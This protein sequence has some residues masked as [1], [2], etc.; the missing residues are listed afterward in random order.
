ML[1]HVCMYYIQCMVTLLPQPLPYTLEHDV[2]V[3]VCVCCVCLFEGGSFITVCCCPV[4]GSNTSLQQYTQHYCSLHTHPPT[5]TLSKYPCRMKDQ[6]VLA[7][8]MH[9]CIHNHNNTHTHTHTHTHIHTHTLHSP[10]SL[11]PSLSPTLPSF[12]PFLPSLP[13]PSTHTTDVTPSSLL[14]LPLPLHHDPS[15][16]NNPPLCQRWE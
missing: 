8:H 11:Y 4:H 14:P 6:S 3:G 5:I 7:T 2:H 9:A 13:P 10:P 15:L 16:F 1:H 12:P